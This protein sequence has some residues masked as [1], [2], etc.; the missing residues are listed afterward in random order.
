MQAKIRQ[1][2]VGDTIQSDEEED[3]VSK[4]QKLDYSK[5]SATTKPTERVTSNLRG[6]SHD[7]DEDTSG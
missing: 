7:V 5:A 2:S 3:E 4:P 6:I 1:Y